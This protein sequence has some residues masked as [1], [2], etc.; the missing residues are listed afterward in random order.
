MREA[1]RFHVVRGGAAI[2]QLQLLE[3]VMHMILDRCDFDL[4]MSCNFLIAQ[5]FVNQP[6]DFDFPS[7]KGCVIEHAVRCLLASQQ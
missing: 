4:E 6:Y 1:L 2:F 5:P 3:N 7:G